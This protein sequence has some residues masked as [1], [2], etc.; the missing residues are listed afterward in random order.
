MIKT[1][2]TAQSRHEFR[3]ALDADLEEARRHLESRHQRGS[4]CS[5]RSTSAAGS[6]GSDSEVVSDPSQAKAG[7][8][9]LWDWSLGVRGLSSP[10]R[11]YRE[12]RAAGR[13]QAL[14]RAFW[15]RTADTRMAEAAEG[16]NEGTERIR[17]AVSPHC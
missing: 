4:R 8:E 7:G 10:R 14:W 9:G 12:G 3:D 2:R 6:V 16:G 1:L 13:V 15:V 5:R 17:R 11:A